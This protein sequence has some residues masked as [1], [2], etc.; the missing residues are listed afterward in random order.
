LP[1]RLSVTVRVSRGAEEASGFLV[2]VAEVVEESISRSLEASEAK[3]LLLSY[4][5][6]KGHRREWPGEQGQTSA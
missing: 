6:P 3:A 5:T 2:C 4:S 1:V